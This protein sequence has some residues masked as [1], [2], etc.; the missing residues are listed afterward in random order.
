MV[1]VAICG[2][3]L[4]VVAAPSGRSADQ[5]VERQRG[6]MLDRAVWHEPLDDWNR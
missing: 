1:A 6:Q 3:L 2:A 4:L 5:L